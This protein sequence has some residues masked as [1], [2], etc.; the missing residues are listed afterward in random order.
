MHGRGLRVRFADVKINVIYNQ[1]DGLERRSAVEA[2]N[3][4]EQGNYLIVDERCGDAIAELIAID[5]ALD[6]DFALE[7]NGTV[8]RDCSI[9]ERGST[10]QIIFLTKGA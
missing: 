3:F 2:Q 7:V 10:C 5:G 4:Y 9:V 6:Q 8:Y 1:P